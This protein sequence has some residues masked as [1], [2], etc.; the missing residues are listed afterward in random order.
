MDWSTF[1]TTFLAGGAGA[2]VTVALV[3][4]WLHFGRERWQRRKEFL[5]HQLHLYGPAYALIAQNRDAFDRIRKIHASSEKHHRGV[6]G[7]GEAVDDTIEVG[8][9]HIREVV[10]PNNVRLERLFNDN[11]H[12]VDPGDIELV[13]QFLHD[14]NNARVEANR[15][16]GPKLP[17]SIKLDLPLISFM[18]PE[19]IERFERQFR[20]KQ[21]ELRRMLRTEQGSWRVT[22]SFRMNLSHRGRWFLRRV[23]VPIVTGL[24]VAFFWHLFNVIKP[25][26]IGLWLPYAY[27]YQYR[28]AT[29]EAGNRT[30]EILRN[31]PVA[32]HAA[33]EPVG[34]VF[35]VGNK[36]IRSLKHAS[37]HLKLP[38]GVTVDD[39]GPFTPFWGNEEYFFYYEDQLINYG[40]IQATERADKEGGSKGAIRLRFEKPGRYELKYFVVGE[41]IKSVVRTFEVN[42]GGG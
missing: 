5:E 16:K 39:A 32:V 18:R 20:A 34:F 15:G 37:L 12:F 19:L 40:V 25:W 14:M 42:V 2:G 3:E 4:S 30:K 11:L 10:E 38:K 17:M 13:T 22:P 33:N 35:A 28:G 6:S 23:C 41:D 7:A 27:E 24:A 21:A 9:Q 26:K 8:N 1:I 29:N 31:V 36:N